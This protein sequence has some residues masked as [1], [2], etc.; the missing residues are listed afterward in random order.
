MLTDEYIPN[1]KL[2]ALISGLILTVLSTVVIA[3][4]YLSFFNVR[5]ENDNVI[6]NWQSSQEI[7]LKTYEVERK[8]STGS[9]VNI[10]EVAAQGDN[11]LYTFVDENVF[12]TDDA[13][14]IY[15]LKIIDNDGSASYSIEVA[16]S[17]SPSPVKRTWGSIK[18]LFR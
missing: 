14:Y 4:A 10:G 6:L 13:I 8:T 9:F 1:M 17:H 16:V 12:K 11:T 3:S 18:A 5:S 2:R 15:R 7:N